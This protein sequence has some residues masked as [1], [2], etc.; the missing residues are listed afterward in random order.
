MISLMEA[1]KIGRLSEFIS[2]QE[3]NGVEKVSKSQFDAIVK[4]SVKEPLPQGQTSGSRAR[5]NSSGKK[6]R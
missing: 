2:E 6:T 1:I 5:G 3:S 4:K